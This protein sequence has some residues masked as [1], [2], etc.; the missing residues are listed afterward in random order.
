MFQR[1]VR[2]EKL[3]MDQLKIKI[4]HKDSG[5]I[6]ELL[7]NV[8][9]LSALSIMKEFIDNLKV[10]GD[11][12][13]IESNDADVKLDLEN[14]V[15]DRARLTWN[16]VQTL[17]LGKVFMRDFGTGLGLVLNVVDVTEE[18]VILRCP[19]NVYEITIHRDD[20]V[21]GRFYFM[22]WDDNGSVAEYWG[23]QST[24]DDIDLEEEV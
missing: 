22:V 23:E 14:Y 16:D 13:I 2:G 10:L 6:V 18:R 19:E 4:T 15:A 17:D 9:R 20:Y 1:N 3:K 7:P 11:K 8:T 5:E 24:D 12:F 21:C